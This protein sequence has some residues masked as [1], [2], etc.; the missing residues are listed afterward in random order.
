M[1]SAADKLHEVKPAWNKDFA[2]ALS[3]ALVVAQ[4]WDLAAAVRD[5]LLA[6]AEKKA[7]SVTKEKLCTNRQ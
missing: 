2:K 4:K 1:S 5:E 3:S 7:P 6:E